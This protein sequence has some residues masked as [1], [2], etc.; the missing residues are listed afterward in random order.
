MN[1]PTESSSGR[2]R[3]SA[4]LAAIL[5]GAFGA[6]RAQ[7]P[8]KDQGLGLEAEFRVRTLLVSITDATGRPL[9]KPPFPADLL[10]RE[11]GKVVKITA[12]EPVRLAEPKGQLPVSDSG[13]DA[14]PRPASRPAALPKHPDMETESL[15]RRQVNAV[16]V[17][18]KDNLEGILRTGALEVVPTNPR[19]GNVGGLYLVTYRSTASPDGSAH[20]HL[21]IASADPGMQIGAPRGL[22]HG[23]A[24]S[25]AAAK[26]TKAPA[27]AQP[28]NEGFDVGVTV[29]A[30]GRSGKKMQG[31]LSV[32]VDLAGIAPALEKLGAGR[33]RVTIEVEIPGYPPF[34][35]HDEA[36][37]DHSSG[38]TMWLYEAKIN[39]P[40]EATRVA[41][42]VEEVK[43]GAR[44]TGVA[45]LPKAP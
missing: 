7:E 16:A 9:S 23:A 11:N 6:V 24:A 26:T 45:E 30:A 41:V 5:L 10:V 33:V 39:W 29:G 43:T 34:V 25:T 44:G 18:G 4:V 27:I 1:F 22:A 40:P 8:P 17:A 36:D 32:S 19:V 14:S 21:S 2:S 12:V 31:E 15:Q 37:L 35:S 28:S 3:G 42:T 20:G 38:G 13:S